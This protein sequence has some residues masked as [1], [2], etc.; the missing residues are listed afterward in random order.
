MSMI[1]MIP[2]EL[3]KRRTEQAVLTQFGDSLDDEAL[4]ELATGPVVQ[5]INLAS[6]DSRGLD[7]CTREMFALAMLIRLGK[8]TEQD[9]KLTF[10]AFRR[11]D[12][13]NEGV[14]N[15]QAIIHGMIRRRASKLNL[16]NLANPKR[17]GTSRSKGQHSTRSAASNLSWSSMGAWI[18]ASP[19]SGE[20]HSDG[21][22]CHIPT[23]SFATSE[24]T[25]LV[26]GP[27]WETMYG[28]NPVL[29]PTR[30]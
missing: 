22:S 6:H 17:N 24:S 13:N 29:I 3:R 26:F 4:R 20:A 30:E 23:P 7:E 5:R 15:S 1:S 28:G 12:V 8:V 2:L 9:I 19:A 14:L 27:G 16:A 21:K 18:G 11:L 25:P 10:A